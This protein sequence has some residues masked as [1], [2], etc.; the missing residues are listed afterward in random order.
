MSEAKEN[1]IS[2][3][4]P[5]QYTYHLPEERI[6]K[7]PSDQRGGSRLLVYSKGKIRHQ[8]FSEVA[9][10]LPAQSLLMFNNTRVIPARMIFHKETGAVIEIFLLEPIAPSRIMSE[11][12]N[13]RDAVTW[14]CMVG[15]AR[16]WKDGIILSKDIETEGRLF[17]VEAELA[18][19]E[20]G[21]VNIRWTD[22]ALTFAE[23]VETVGKVP[24]PPYINRELDEKD[25]ERYQTVYSK[26][27]GAVAAPTA[28]LHFTDEVIGSFSDKNIS[29]DEVTLHVSAG[30]F[31]PLKAEKLED[32]PMHSEQIIINYEN[33]Q[34]I[35][36]AKTIIAVGTTSMR[37]LES[38]YWY[39]VKLLAE[40]SKEF[41]IDKLYPYTDRT[42]PTKK[43]AFGAVLAHM[44]ALETK[45]LVGETEIFIFPGYDFKVCDGLVTNFHLPGS[46][47]ILLVAAFIGENWRSVYEEALKNDYRFLSYGDSS[48]LLP[49]KTE[50]TP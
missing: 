25:P 17:T 21:Y 45:L 41:H 37:T 48:I 14:K 44:E 29:T 2:K 36:E 3:I 34:N 11:A 50:T 32:H 6:A 16:K 24:L 40:E 39:G 35:I 18:D 27:E 19:K 7:F 15:N 13:A 31:Q 5:K 4:N 30:T 43:K 23:V 47:L 22:H 49:G 9:D 12:M 28:G 1:D 20:A 42:L 26:V 33:L 38:T 46:T 8:Y 10:F